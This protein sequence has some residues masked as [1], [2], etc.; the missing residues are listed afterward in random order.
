MDEGFPDAINKGESLPDKDRVYRIVVNT[1]RD[2]KNK[3]IPAHRCFS[4]SENDNGKLSVDWEQKTT[5]EESIAR[6]GASF[7]YNSK[8]FKPFKNR[9]IYALEISFL[10]SLSDI[11]DV[12][13]DPISSSM[14]IKARVN[15]PAH[16]LIV[17]NDLFPTH[18]PETYIKL[19]DHAKNNKIEVDIQKVGDLVDKLRLDIQ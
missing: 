15:N 7:K 18:D 4:L 3:R 9:E 10:K 13:Y 11:D 17:F 6:F 14:D 19:R 1:E 2:R 16:S 12:I 5:P 8:E